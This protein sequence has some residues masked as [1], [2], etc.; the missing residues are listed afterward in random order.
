M[1]IV[2][3]NGVV[4]PT[5]RQQDLEAEVS[6]AFQKRLYNNTI[7]HRK[8]ITGAERKDSRGVR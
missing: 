1:D 4:Q 7:N 8:V 6:K 5:P 3:K 2:Y